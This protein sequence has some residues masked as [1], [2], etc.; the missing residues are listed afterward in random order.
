M[1]TPQTRPSAP[2]SARPAPAQPAPAS[3]RLRRPLRHRR[4]ARARERAI[5][6]IDAL[7]TL[8][9][10]CN[11]SDLETRVAAARRRLEQTTCSVLVVGEFKKGKSSLINALVNAPI[12]PVD[13]DAA[14]AKP[15]EVHYAATPEASVVLRAVSPTERTEDMP[16]VTRPLDFDDIPSYAAEP[17]SAPDAD[18]VAAVRLGLPRQL[19]A[20]GLVL[21]DTPGVGGLGL[22]PQRGHRERAPLGGRRA[23]RHRRLAGADRVGAR[24]PPAPRRRC[25]RR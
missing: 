17:T 5:A 6:G 12:C 15:I 18:Q 3:P 23:V 13:D 4:R 24:V 21:V 8:L 19:L 10:R 25:A 11:R 2:S 1:T 9:S 7:T 20:T 14:T 22:D 16:P